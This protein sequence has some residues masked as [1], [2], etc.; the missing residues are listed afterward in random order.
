[1][2]LA[3]DAGFDKEL[4]GYGG[5]GLVSGLHDSHSIGEVGHDW[6]RKTGKPFGEI[7]KIVWSA[8]RDHAK[9][10]NWLPVAYEF[11]DEPRSAR[12]GSEKCGAYAALS[13]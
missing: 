10:N 3:R 6:E 8:V 4:N 1:M 9:E 13:R 5:P 11:I 7:L 2:K 12:T